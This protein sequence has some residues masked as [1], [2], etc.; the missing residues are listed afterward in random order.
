MLIDHRAGYDKN[1]GLLLIC[2]FFVRAYDLSE[3]VRNE[4]PGSDKPG[5]VNGENVGHL[6]NVV[7]AWLTFARF[8]CAYSRMS[9]R[10]LEHPAKSR[11]GNPEALS[12][13]SN[14]IANSFFHAYPLI[15]GGACCDNFIPIKKFFTKS[16]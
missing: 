16:I 7:D 4:F 15:T 9:Y 6:G 10:R 11:R 2:H 12:S 3:S 5:K 1:C 14:Y 8:P 13:F